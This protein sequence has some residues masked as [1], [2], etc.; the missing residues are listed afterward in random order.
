MTLRRWL[1]LLCFHAT[2]SL[3]LQNP[4]THRTTVALAKKKRT[5]TTSAGKGFGAAAPCPCGSGRSSDVCCDRVRNDRAAASPAEIVRS[6]YTAYSRG[7]WQYVVETTDDAAHAPE[8]RA[9]WIA[10]L[11][12]QPYKD[13][14]F[15]GADI[16]E[17]HVHD[18]EAVVLFVAKLKDKR[19]NSRADFTER[20][21]FNLC[22]DRGWLYVSGDIEAQRTRYT[23]ED[24]PAKKTK[25]LAQKSPRREE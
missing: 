3:V 2:R 24:D 10:D 22:S 17:E 18:T 4:R 9:E 1:L 16:L 14:R 25:K 19:T 12:K 11:Q 23:A 21:Y 5:A 7:D 6:R 20:S 13:Y 8:E 15:L